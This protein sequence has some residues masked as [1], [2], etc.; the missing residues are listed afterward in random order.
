MDDRSG[1]LVDLKVFNV[2]SRS[3]T[4]WSNSCSSH[5]KGNITFPPATRVWGQCLNAP[6]DIEHRLLPLTIV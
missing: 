6:S 2:V 1:G 3:V 5:G 4:D